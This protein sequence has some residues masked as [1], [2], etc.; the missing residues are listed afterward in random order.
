MHSSVQFF[1]YF[2]WNT[3]ITYQYITLFSGFNSVC[4]H[5]LSLFLAQRVKESVTRGHFEALFWN[6]GSSLT[7]PGK[8]FGWIEP[9]II[10]F[11]IILRIFVFSLDCELFRALHVYRMNKRPM[12]PGWTSKSLDTSKI[13][14]HGSTCSETGKPWC[15]DTETLFTLIWRTVALIRRHWNKEK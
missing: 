3:D 15:Q 5:R 2:E 12:D 9:P 1:N 8:W 7:C 6:V 11:Y 14:I 10:V 13:S 4:S